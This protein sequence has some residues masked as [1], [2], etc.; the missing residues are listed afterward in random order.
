MSLSERTK[1]ALLFE[2]YGGFLPLTLFWKSGKVV[3]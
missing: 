3:K 1:E 2:N